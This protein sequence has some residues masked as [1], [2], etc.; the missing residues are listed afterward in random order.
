MRLFFALRPPRVAAGQLAAIA[1][2]CAGQFGGQ[3][4]R[5]ETIHLTLAFLGD[6]TEAQISPLVENAQRLRLPPFDLDINC[7]GSWAHNRLLWAGCTALP[8][9]LQRLA[10]SLHDL[11]REMDPGGK[12]RRFMPHLTLVRKLTVI[13]EELNM[14]KIE[15]IHWSCTGFVLVQS[16]LS[17]APKFQAVSEFPLVVE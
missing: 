7:L 15:P 2:T 4:S 10:D 6:M 16:R 5:E 12:R 8:P 14:P 11:V 9:E 1:R 3:P 13:G 17:A